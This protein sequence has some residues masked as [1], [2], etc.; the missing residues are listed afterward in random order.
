MAPSGPRSSGRTPEGSDVDGIDVGQTAPVPL[1]TAPVSR[2]HPLGVRLRPGG[3]EVAVL[4]A[5]ADGVWF[6]VLE[7][8]DGGLLERQVEL[9]R[10]THGVWHGFVPDVDVGTR[11]GYR[12]AGRW[13]PALGY[14]HNPAKFLLDPYARALDGRL[15]LRPEALRARRR[16]AVRRGPGGARTDAT[17]HLSSRTAW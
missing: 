3:V 15:R 10:R 6:C 7:P 4:A 17:R 12:V 2:P 11:Y 13:E 9:T 1:D 14:R 16:R 5:H 8:A